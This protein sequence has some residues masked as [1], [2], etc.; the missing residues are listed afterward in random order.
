MVQCAPVTSL[1]EASL[2]KIQFGIHRRQ[3]APAREVQVATVIDLIRSP[4]RA[5]RRL[6][7]GQV[8]RGVRCGLVMP[9]WRRWPLAPGLPGLGP[10]GACALLVVA[11]AEE[12]GEDAQLVCQTP[13]TPDT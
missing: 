13:R 10:V 2:A 7:A 6:G 1:V 12:W 9:S 4:G 8:K 11:V 3:R 5:V